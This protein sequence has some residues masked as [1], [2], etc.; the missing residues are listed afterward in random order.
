MTSRMLTVAAA[1]GFFVLASCGGKKVGEGGT[2]RSHKDC[3]KGLKCVNKVCS[4]VSGDSP[5]CRWTLQCLK[6]LSEVNPKNAKE[7]FAQETAV[8]WYKSLKKLPLKKDCQKLAEKGIPMGQYPWVWKPLCG[9]PPIKGIVK[10]G[11][12]NPFKILDFKITGSLVPPDDKLHQVMVGPGHYPDVCKAWVK[13]EVTRQFQGRVVAQFFREYDCVKKKVKDEETHK[14]VEKEECKLRP[15]ERVD[16]LLYLYLTKPGQII[17][18]N[19]Y[20]ETPP[21]VCEGRTQKKY[22]T[23]CLCLGLSDKKIELKAI[24][25][26]FLTPADFEMAKEAEKKRR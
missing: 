14:M 7:R 11:G 16:D 10:T 8:R 12:P 9:P 4:D 5:V 3:K 19:F 13:F 20:V 25:D 17:E 18:R 15:Y 23:G 24:E 1:L 6:K 21:E 2:C 26:P 22:P